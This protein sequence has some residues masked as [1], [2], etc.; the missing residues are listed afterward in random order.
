MNNV[1]NFNQ[2]AGAK[3]DPHQGRES[4]IYDARRTNFTQWGHRR[5]YVGMLLFALL[6]TC[7]CFS[8]SLKEG[9]F[10]PIILLPA[11]WLLLLCVNVP[12]RKYIAH[13]SL[14]VM[15]CAFS[16]RYALYPAVIILDIDSSYAYAYNME[17]VLLMLSELL[18]ANLIIAIFARKLNIPDRKKDARSKLGFVSGTL[19]LIAIA[20]ALAYPS[21]L[22][23]FSSSMNVVRGASAPQLVLGCYQLGLWVL[24][25]WCLVKCRNMSASDKGIFNAILSVFTVLICVQYILSTMLSRNGVSRWFLISGAISLGYVYLYLF[26][27]NRKRKIRIL[28][29]SIIVGVFFATFVKFQQEASVQ[30]FL[31]NYLLSSS[32][33]D[34][35][36]GGV[37]NIQ[38]GLNA[39][40]NHPEFQSLSA[41]TTTIFMNMPVISRFFPGAAESDVI[42]CYHRYIN[43]DWLI[44]PLVVQS[45]AHFGKLAS[46]L[47]AM[48]FTYL[49]I[50][51]DVLRKKTS[52]LSVVFVSLEIIFFCSMFSA[53]NTRIIFPLI[54]LRIL[55]IL[56]VALEGWFRKISV[57]R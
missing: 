41:V 49:A 33:L 53:L 43:A 31:D 51:F 28:V 46:Y 18:G 39:I 54:W 26:P 15:G 47:F 48:L 11:T 45:V 4:L 30:S 56:L 40:K 35:Y 10:V 24:V 5:V 14:L 34:D 2:Q 42:A 25:I 52:N 3:Q 6:C 23:R 50:S 55:F 57:R 38:D 16:L 9:Q 20:C 32:M 22:L 36:F 13:I 7:I 37:R 17:A 27:H 8:F 1:G 19:L 21:L 12:F 44:C 29:T